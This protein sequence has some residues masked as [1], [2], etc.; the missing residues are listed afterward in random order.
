MGTFILYYVSVLEK[1]L[2]LASTKATANLFLDR[3]TPSP[4]LIGIFGAQYLLKYI[5]RRQSRVAIE[6]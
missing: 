1:S 6:K 3:L 4:I 2:N 5:P